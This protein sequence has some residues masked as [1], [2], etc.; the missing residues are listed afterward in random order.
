MRDTGKTRADGQH[1]LQKKRRLSIHADGMKRAM[2]SG[3]ADS[4]P[5]RAGTLSLSDFWDAIDGVEPA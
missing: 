2:S 5:R 4:R 3:P 1:P